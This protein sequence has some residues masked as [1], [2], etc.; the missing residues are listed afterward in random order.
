MVWLASSTP[1]SSPAKAMIGLKVEP[2]ANCAC[3]ARFI[4]G[5]SPLEFSC[6]QY[7]EETPAAKAFKS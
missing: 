2:G 5:L 6:F 3:I 1:A 7:S 4:K